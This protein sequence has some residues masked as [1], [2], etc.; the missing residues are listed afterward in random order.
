[1]IDSLNQ[2]PIKR[3]VTNWYRFREGNSEAEGTGN[4]SY[5]KDT[6]R[7]IGLFSLEVR[8]WGI[9]VAH[10]CGHQVSAGQSSRCCSGG[11]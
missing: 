1:M 9:M 4:T 8:G 3:T 6:Q 11:C 10:K 5:E 7:D 2:R